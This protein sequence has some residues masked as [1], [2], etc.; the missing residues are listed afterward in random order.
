MKKRC[1]FC[2]KVK[3]GMTLM[4]DREKREEGRRAE[5]K[6]ACQWRYH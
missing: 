4:N 3:P 2:G 6:Y 5:K 1:Q